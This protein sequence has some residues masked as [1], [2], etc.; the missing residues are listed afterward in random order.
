MFHIGMWMLPVA[1]IPLILILI[2]MYFL[3]RR[4]SRR[5][6]QKRRGLQT[7]KRRGNDLT[8]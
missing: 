3:A 4:R 5:L 1:G 8:G 2:W 7:A 6:A